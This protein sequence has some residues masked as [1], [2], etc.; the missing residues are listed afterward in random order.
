MP[1]SASGFSDLG[2]AVSD[3]F[4][5]IGSF[6]Q[7]KGYKAAAGYAASNA[8]ITEQSTRIQE[9]QQQRTLEKT[10]GGQQSDV[11]G[12][13]LAASGSALD[14]FRDSAQQGSLTKQL[15]A[16]QGAINV[17]GY[18]AEAA[19]YSAQASAASAAGKGGILSG[20]IKGVSAVA[21]FAMLSDDRMKED[22]VLHERRPDGIGL[23]DFRYKGDPAV[24]RGVLASEVE[25]LYPS[26]I[27]WIDG[28]RHVNYGLIGVAPEVVHA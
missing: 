4:G 20:I 6:A 21:S 15:I 27:Q 2:G 10:L 9:Y 13:G 25:R 26:A 3:I 14:L 23:Y 18:K 24:F 1:A 11:A 19:S 7:A 22:I 5:A 28:L 17:Q 8:E 16:N 12:A